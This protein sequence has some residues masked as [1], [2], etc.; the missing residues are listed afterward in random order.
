MAHLAE[1]RYGKARV[2]VMKVVRHS[3][4]HELKEWSVR[5]LLHGDFETCFTAGDNSKILPTD[6]MKNTVYSLARDSKAT[7]PEVFAM[8]LGQYLLDNNGQV[9]AVSVDVEEKK[10]EHVL[11]SGKPHPTTYSLNGAELQ[12]AS[13]VKPRG[14]S[15]EIVSG[16]DGLVILK[17]TDSE[18]T[19]Y[20]KDKLTTL[21]ETTD[22]IFA[23]RATITWGYSTQP[24]NFT[25]IRSTV[26]DR[27]LTTF[28]GHHSL[29]VQHTIYDIGVAVL[30]AVSEISWIKMTMPNL[31]CLPVNLEPFGQDNPN[32]IFV[33]TDE[34]H[35][36]IEATIRR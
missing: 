26:L 36:Y 31:H 12:A 6:T 9:T 23:T 20:I 28:A 30:K 35:G 3:T 14:G 7:T 18:F 34:P 32:M 27:V 4:H 25:A 11:V 1:N 24:K 2:R 5:V 21:K 22:R 29:S 10:W 19:G 16:I 15:F 13:V 33:P 17:T 8:E